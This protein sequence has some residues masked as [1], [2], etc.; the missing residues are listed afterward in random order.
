M[1]EEPKDNKKLTNWIHIIHRSENLV[2]LFGSNDEQKTQSSRKRN[3]VSKRKDV[4]V[5]WN[6]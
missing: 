1:G 2:K 5:D 3:I 4:E 6:H